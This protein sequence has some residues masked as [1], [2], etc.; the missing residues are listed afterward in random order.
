MLA[1]LK[2]PEDMGAEEFCVG[3]C[4]EYCFPDELLGLSV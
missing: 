4:T 3:P 2:R 1:P